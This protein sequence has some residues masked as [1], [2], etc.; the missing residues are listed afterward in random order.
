MERSEAANNRGQ[1][2]V[3]SLG[4][5]V[6]LCACVIAATLF[7]GA[8]LHRVS[9]SPRSPFTAR[10]NPNNASVS[11]LARLP[12]VG[13]TRA[14]AIADF[15]DDV[16]TRQGRREVFRCAEDLAQVKGIGPAT[17][18]AMRPWLQFDPAADGNDSAASR[19]GT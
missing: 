2:A 8:A 17:V 15:R 3:Q 12:G 9:G 19:G 5:L 1:E 16:K 4:F 6:G 13:A 10:V 14:R 11:S 18:E 7:A